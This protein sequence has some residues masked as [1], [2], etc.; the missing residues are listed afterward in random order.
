MHIY[1]IFRIVAGAPKWIRIYLQS[2]KICGNRCRVAVHCRH[3]HWPHRCTSQLP[4]PKKMQPIIVKHHRQRHCSRPM[5]LIMLNL[6]IINWLMIVCRIVHWIYAIIWVVPL[7][8]VTIHNNYQIF[9]FQL[10]IFLYFVIDLE[11]GGLLPSPTREKLMPAITKR[12]D[13]SY[14]SQRG[15]PKKSIT[16]RH[17]SPQKGSPQKQAK[18][19]VKQTKGTH[20]CSGRS[21]INCFWNIIFL[22]LP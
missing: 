3:C 2:K 20:F 18:K 9:A 11:D 14:N 13:E 1:L 12:D 15:S 17:G 5:H 8:M 21:S 16:S 19:P 22:F 4:K 10:F 6:L 7:V